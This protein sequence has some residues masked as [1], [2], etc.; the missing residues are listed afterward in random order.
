MTNNSLLYRQIVDDIS[1]KIRSGA[2]RPGE[3]VPSVTEIRSDFQVSHITALR[4][5]K[6]LTADG[7]IAKQPGLGYFAA[8]NTAA[9]NTIRTVGCLMRDI[10]VLTHDHYFNEIMHGIQKEAGVYRFNTLFPHLS[11]AIDTKQI[12]LPDDVMKS[13]IQQ[14]ELVHGFIID[15]RID[16]EL[17]GKIIQLTG[18]PIVILDR[19]SELKINSVFADNRGGM[20]K[21]FKTLLRMGYKHF[22]YADSGQAEYN[23]DMR[24]LAFREI[25]ME[26][27]VAPEQYRVLTGCSVYP[28]QEMLEAFWPFVKELSGQKTA[29]ICSSDG[30]ARRLCTRLLEAGYR[31]PE[32]IGIC[33]FGGMEYTTMCKPELTTLKIDTIQMGS[34]AMKT[35]VTLIS[36]STTEQPQ[37]CALPLNL[38]FGETI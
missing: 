19:S 17:V 15:P 2:I 22:I 24:R 35:L 18:K 37:Q 25:A 6:E 34:Q 10:S 29:I 7:I 3:R 8:E 5:L 23:Q 11:T 20:D 33:S 12:L 36:N 13:V 1:R 26:Q 4:A 16:D 27:K 14:K 32:D 30:T 9:D 28:E 21:L 31:I 38:I